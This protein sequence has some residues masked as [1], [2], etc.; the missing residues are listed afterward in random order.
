MEHIGLSEDDIDKPSVVNYADQE[1][2]SG[3]YHEIHKN[4]LIEFTGS[5]CDKYG[6]LQIIKENKCCDQT[7]LTYKDALSVSSSLMYNFYDNSEKLAPEFIAIAGLASEYNIEWYYYGVFI[8][9]CWQGL[10][11][12]S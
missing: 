6:E 10:N 12:S 2:E 5:L 3:N 1:L 11:E 7:V 8:R 9:I 4:I